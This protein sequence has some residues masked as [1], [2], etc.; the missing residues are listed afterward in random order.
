MSFEV[1]YDPSDVIEK[2][3]V[4][5]V[6]A[7]EGN[8]LTGMCIVSTPACPD[9]NAL[10]MVAELVNAEEATETNEVN[11]EVPNEEGTVIA[12]E[13]KA[14]EAVATAETEETIAENTEN[15]EATA[16]AE[17]AEAEVVHEEVEVRESFTKDP[18]DDKTY[19]EVKTEH[20]IVET[21]E[22]EPAAEPAAVVA[23]CGGR[24]EDM[25][26]CG[27]P[28]DHRI[29]ELEAELAR[30]NAELQAFK[31]AKMA[32]ELKVKQDKA[33]AFAE[34]Q[35]L[36]VEDENVAQAIAE[37]NYE[38][39][40]ELAMAETA[41]EAEEEKKTIE[42]TMASYVDMSLPNDEYGG[43]LKRPNR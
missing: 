4:R 18:Y 42:I 17:T 26:E 35:G 34:K 33:K 10:D 36:N 7:G 37:V 14:E 28:R 41:N 12:E 6:D 20:T 9:A 5:F 15:A 3:G 30:V 8:S 38:M 43:L 11:E 39:I 21:V 40:A 27:D 22:E 31:D 19:H 25:G 24:K 16:T 29:A 2:D 32:A 1:K 13:V 23:D